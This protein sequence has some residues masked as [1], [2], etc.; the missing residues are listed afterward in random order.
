V[1]LAVAALGACPAVAA[2]QDPQT[3]GAQAPEP[4]T[5]KSAPAAAGSGTVTAQGAVAVTARAD[6]MYGRVARFRGSVGR[7]AAGQEVAIERHDDATAAWTE[8]AT[9]T[10]AGDGSFLARWRTDQLGRVRLRA[11]VRGAGT[12]S[13]AGSESPELAVTVYRG[14]LATWY[15]PGFFG[16]RTACGQK[17]THALLGVAHRRLPCGTPVALYY[18]GRTLVVPVVDRG[19]FRRGASWDL[20]AGAAIALGFAFTDRLGA[21]RLPP[22]LAPPV[23]GSA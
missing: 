12:A 16:H 18:K 8:V 20:T 15:G 5:A 11:V 7:G 21:V 14:A 22:E 13:A 10:A 2:A 4:V 17:L 19:P 23:P 6:T 3:G 1:A 9:A